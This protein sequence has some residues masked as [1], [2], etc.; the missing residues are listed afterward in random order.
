M[1]KARLLDRF[2]LK[3]TKTDKY[4]KVAMTKG[5]QKALKE[6]INKNYEGNIDEYL[7]K[8]RKRDKEETLSQLIVRV[9]GELFSKRRNK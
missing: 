8:S 3:E 6:Y 1:V 9:R 7:F 2:T 5:V 4:N